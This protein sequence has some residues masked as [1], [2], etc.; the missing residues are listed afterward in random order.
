M[1]YKLSENGFDAVL[2]M[3]FKCVIGRGYIKF[4]EEK[5]NEL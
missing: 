3:L 2:R 5:C 4:G 1:I